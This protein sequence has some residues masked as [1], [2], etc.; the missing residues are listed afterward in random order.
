MPSP[1]S[2][3]GSSCAGASATAPRVADSSAAHFPLSR[4]AAR[5]PTLPSFCFPG[6]PFLWTA[7]SRAFLRLTAWHLHQNSPRKLI[8]HIWHAGVS[9]VRVS[10]S[11]LHPSTPLLVNSSSPRSIGSATHVLGSGGLYLCVWRSVYR[12]FE[13]CALW[14]ERST[15]EK[16][17]S[18]LRLHVASRTRPYECGD[19]LYHRSLLCGCMRKRRSLLSSATRVL[20]LFAPLCRYFLMLTTLVFLLD[21]V[22]TT[23]SREE[24]CI[25]PLRPRHLPVGLHREHR[26]LFLPCP[27]LPA[28]P[29]PHTH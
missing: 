4:D 8:F 20:A 6:L 14:M 3:A 17:R 7:R 11:S 25:R 28:F 22:S 23:P 27:T 10:S 9:I 13:S 5:P 21:I 18:G 15:Y 29:C 1:L 19:V 26:L 24:E 2:A 16:R 12:G